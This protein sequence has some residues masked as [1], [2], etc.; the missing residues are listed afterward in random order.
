MREVGV[1]DGIVCVVDHLTSSEGH[2]LQVRRKVSK[3]LGIKSSQEPV[4]AGVGIRN[5]YYRSSLP[6]PK[7]HHERFCRS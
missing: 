1:S 6:G 3:V 5:G 7:F 2:R 4:G